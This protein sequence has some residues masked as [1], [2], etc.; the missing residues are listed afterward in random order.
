MKLL[1]DS[2]PPVIMD[3]ERSSLENLSTFI[4]YFFIG[5]SEG[6]RLCWGLLQNGSHFLQGV[7]EYD[8]I[9]YCVLNV[10]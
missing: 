5:I 2:L 8:T 6:H 4:R 7:L 1:V 10:Q 3:V 9:R